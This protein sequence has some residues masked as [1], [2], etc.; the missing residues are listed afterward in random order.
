MDALSLNFDHLTVAEGKELEKA[1]GMSIGKIF[2]SLSSGDYSMD[3]L[4]GMLYVIGKRDNPA[5]TID[6]V[7]A[8]DMMTLN[9]VPPQ[10]AATEETS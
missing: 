6:D 1:T 4:S 3:I 7:D 2:D 5:M 8:I 10:P 9:A